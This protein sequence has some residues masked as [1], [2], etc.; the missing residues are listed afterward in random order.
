MYTEEQYLADLEKISKEEYS[1]LAAYKAQSPTDNLNIYRFQFVLLLSA[2]K[3]N[4]FE[5]ARTV[6]NNNAEV[7]IKF[8]DNFDLN[9]LTNEN[10]QPPFDFL[11]LTFMN[12][13][14]AGPNH[15]LFIKLFQ[16]YNTIKKYL[17]EFS[18]E[19]VFLNDRS[20][21]TEVSMPLDEARNTVQARLDYLAEN[22]ASLLYSSGQHQLLLTFLTDFCLEN[23]TTNE[24]TLSQLGR[25][26]LACGDNQM[27]STF[28]GDVKDEGL[29]SANQ[30]YISFYSSA[31][32]SARKEF[33]AA[34][35]KGPA[36][37]DA[38]LKY[39]GQF[40]TDPSESTAVK[41][42]KQT[43]EDRTQWPMQP[44]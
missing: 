23:F 6:A 29:K 31:F 19:T 20:R 36:N 27:A 25:V 1:D 13:T 43:A 44:R 17:S 35:E 5:N 10:P 16:H 14:T 8:V 9:L 40:T 28:F 30:G 21:P 37:S 39:M 2:F 42:K 3:K 7:L 41:A 22:I 33:Q 11:L 32:Q 38:C 18:G 15:S 26:A 34:G 24:T 12:S 4:D